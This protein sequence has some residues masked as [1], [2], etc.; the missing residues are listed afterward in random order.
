[1][2][3]QRVA[4]HRDLHP[5][6]AARDDLENRAAGVGHPHGV[7]ELRHVLFRSAVLREIPGQHE[8]GFEHRPGLPNPAV[9]RGA[10]P[11]VDGMAD[12]S[13]H[14]L[15]CI[16]RAALIPGSVELLGN[17][18]ELDDKVLAEVLRFD[19]ASLLPPEP[20]KPCLV[21]AHDDPGVRTAYE[22]TAFVVHSCKGI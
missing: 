22:L 1:M 6:S 8:L 11:V 16:T 21:V 2:L 20:E 12:P 18:A 14:I 10:H 7:L 13:L 9:E 15:D 3:I 5:L 4:V 17:A 19:L